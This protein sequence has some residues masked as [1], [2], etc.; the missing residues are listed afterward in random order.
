MAGKPN[1]V[2]HQAYCKKDIAPIVGVEWQHKFFV[3]FI[4]ITAQIC[5]LGYFLVIYPFN[6]N[7]LH[8]FRKFEG[9]LSLL[10]RCITKILI[11][12]YFGEFVNNHF[13]MN[14]S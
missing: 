14:M 9:Y 4:A 7:K 6:N 1:V 11:L 13:L 8:H 10:W 2:I 5:G 3:P 12:Q